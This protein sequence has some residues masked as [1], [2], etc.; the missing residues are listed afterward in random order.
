MRAVL[1]P[2]LILAATLSAG[3]TSDSDAQRALAAAG[4]TDV[5]LNGYSWFSCGKDDTFHTAF[6]ARGPTGVPVSGVVCS[7]WFKG[8]TIRID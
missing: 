1:L 4:Y 7:G 5:Q 2:L 8:S 3:C 6:T